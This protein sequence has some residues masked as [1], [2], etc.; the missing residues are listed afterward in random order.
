LSVEDHHDKGISNKDVI[1]LLLE[2]VSLSTHY[3][4]SGLTTF[5]TLELS[6]LVIYGY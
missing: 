2:R 5:S 3:L 6:S 4:T 1:N